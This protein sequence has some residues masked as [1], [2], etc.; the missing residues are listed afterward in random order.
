MDKIS[1]PA[2]VSILYG[3]I[4]LLL[5]SLFFVPNKPIEIQPYKIYGFVVLSAL[6]VYCLIDY[7]H[8]N[9]RNENNQV[10]M[11]NKVLKQINQDL[12]LQIDSQ[13]SKEKELAFHAAYDEL[14]GLY[15]RRKGL[16]LF[17][18]QLAL[19][20]Q[21]KS[22][23]LVCFIDINGLKIINDTYGH[24]E[25][26]IL[27]TAFSNIFKNNLDE[28]NI[29]C[30]LGGDEF[31]ITFPNASMPQMESIRH[32]LNLL[33]Q[34]YNQSSKKPYDLSCSYGFSEYD[35]RMN[36][37]LDN[38][39]INADKKMYVEKEVRK[40]NLLAKECLMLCSLYS[41]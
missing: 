22:N 5:L 40:N 36:T 41:K 21:T 20:K 25:G 19:S 1:T 31:L 17:R 38:L 2:K 3:F 16:Q 28:D 14:T 33:I 26:D 23:L 39:I 13:H 32:K 27:I 30:R 34:S 15:N 12:R 11:Q 4:T 37:D 8:I 35:Y 6:I 24:A 9:L 29:I 10:V 7:H 18:E